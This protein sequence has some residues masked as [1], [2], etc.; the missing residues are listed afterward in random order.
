MI[1]DIIKLQNT[2]VDNNISNFCVLVYKSPYFRIGTQSSR[3][4]L[5]GDGN[6]VEEQVTVGWVVHGGG[7]TTVRK[8]ETSQHCVGLDPRPLPT[9]HSSQPYGLL[10]VIE[11]CMTT[12]RIKA[13]AQ[14]DIKRLGRVVTLTNK[15]LEIVYH[16]NEREYSRFRSYLDSRTGISFPYTQPTQNPKKGVVDESKPTTGTLKEI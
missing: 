9:S 8:G 7:V 10:R 13:D 14:Y 12:K 2:C 3:S 5:S 16:M 15:M 11:K 4:V 6:E 1:Y